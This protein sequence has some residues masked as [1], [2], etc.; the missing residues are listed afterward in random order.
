MQVK[1]ILLI[2]MISPGVEGQWNHPLNFPAGVFGG[3]KKDKSP[4]SGAVAWY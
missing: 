4:L 3:L 2:M 1:Y